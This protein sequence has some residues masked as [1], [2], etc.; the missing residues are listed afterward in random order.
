MHRNVG[1][2]KT[3]LRTARLVGTIPTVAHTG[4]LA[5]LWDD[6]RVTVTLGGKRSREVVEQM[7]D[8]WQR[9]WNEHGFGPLVWR[10]AGT[11]QFVG[12]CGLQWT[13]VAGK[14]AIELLYGIAA[15]R[16]GEGLATEASQEVLRWADDELHLDELVCFTLTTNVASRNVMQKCGFTYGRGIEHAGLPHVLYRRDVSSGR[17]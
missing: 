10:D 6:D 5:T 12:W 8:R 17:G 1:A 16:W 11:G 15:E 4:D 2:V 7:V 14:P 9:H 3:E 13:A